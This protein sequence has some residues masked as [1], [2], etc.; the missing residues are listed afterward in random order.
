MVTKLARLEDKVEGKSKPTVVMNEQLK[1]F[2]LLTLRLFDQD[3]ATEII[4]KSLSSL[5]QSQKKDVTV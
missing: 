5:I 1:D 4:D 3:K 2:I